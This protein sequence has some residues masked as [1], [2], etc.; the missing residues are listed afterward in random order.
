MG[1]VPMK[2]IIPKTMKKIT[3][4]KKLVFAL[5]VG[6]GFNGVSQ[7]CNISFIH[8]N[9]AN[10]IVTFTSTSINVNTVT[11][12]YF[13]NFGD[14]NTA[15]GTN[16]IFANNTYTANG[17]YIVSLFVISPS[18]PTCSNQVMDTVIINNATT[19]TCAINANFS[20]AHGSNG[21]V[22][23]FNTSTGTVSGTTYAWNFG[24]G[25]NSTLLSPSHTYS[26][27][28][29][30]TVTLTANNNLSVTCLSTKTMVVNVNSYCNIN[31]SFAYTQ[32]ANGQ[33]SFQ[34]T[35]TGT[36]GASAYNWY[37][38]SNGTAFGPNPVKTFTANGTY[39]VILSVSSNSTL[40]CTD[41][42]S[43]QITVTSNTCQLSAGFTYTNGS[44]GQITF[45]N[46]STGTNAN[47]TYNW[48]FGNGFNSNSQNP[49]AQTYLNGGV[50]LVTLTISDAN[51][52]NC[53]ST[54]TQTVNV[55]SIPCTANA[56]F[57]LVPTG[58]LQIWNAVPAYPYNLSSITWSWG[59]GD[60][61]SVLY[62]S[63]QY[64]VAGNYNICLTVMATCGATATACNSY[65]IY[66]SPGGAADII[67]VNVIPPTPQQVVNTTGI[68]EN[69]NMLSYKVFPNPS[70]GKFR[71]QLDGLSDSHVKVRIYDI[72]GSL[73][74]Q[75][76]ITDAGDSA[77]K[78][79]ELGA[80]ADGIY[81]IK[82]DSGTKTFTQKIVISK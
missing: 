25:G 44:S 37:F 56:N 52:P 48:N 47:T 6:I 43:Q 23:F 58:T 63:H 12:N 57:T 59:D 28:G 24:D 31:A 10:G 66:K 13:W 42:T 3:L 82:L 27:N 19:P 1:I 38:Q 36:T 17:I 8:T 73:V 16:M 26:A 60:T 80:S 72:V 81:F 5:L 46:T 70:N 40:G 75:T 54:V 61:S 34:S 71:I 41:S 55:T 7:N 33:V 14:G 78:E 20:P 2:H 69:N 21:L 30:Y 4:L 50:H 18:A 15:S 45:N 49:S 22:T 39:W 65:S 35:S 67:Q 68:S 62:T 53:H 77:T 79:V 76:N 32:G 51:N 74:H 29:S 9:G 64:S 11:S